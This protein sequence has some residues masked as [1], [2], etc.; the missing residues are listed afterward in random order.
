MRHAPLA[1]TI[2]VTVLWVLTLTYAPRIGTIPLIAVGALAAFSSRLPSWG[3]PIPAFPPLGITPF[4]LTLNFITP[5]A[6]TVFAT[7]FY[8]VTPF[9]SGFKADSLLALLGGVSLAASW[10]A[11]RHARQASERAESL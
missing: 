4:V 5:Y 9:I 8:T 1:Y 6:F 2:L 10:W 7:L 3:V 11:S